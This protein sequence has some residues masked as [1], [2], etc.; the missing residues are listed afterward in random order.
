[1]LCLG[2]VSVR[3]TQWTTTWTNFVVPHWHFLLVLLSLEHEYK[4]GKVTFRTCCIYI[5]ILDYINVWKRFVSWR[6]VNCKWSLMTF[7]YLTTKW[8]VPYFR[9]CILFIS[10]IVLR[11]MLISMGSIG[12]PLPHLS[13]VVV[14][15]LF[16]CSPAVLFTWMLVVTS[17]FGWLIEGTAEKYSSK[18]RFRSFKCQ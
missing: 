17:T 7:L 6:T 13:H 2:N 18:Q 12:G 3:W 16:L 4:L 8:H 11:S 9:I 1:M 15:S 10:M 5:D 14:L